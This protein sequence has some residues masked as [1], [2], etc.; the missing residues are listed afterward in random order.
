MLTGAVAACGLA[1]SGVQTTTQV[2][3][4]EDAKAQP[5]RSTLKVG[6]WTL[7]HDRELT[8]TPQT[9]AALQSCAR[10]AAKTLTNA[11][12][13]KAEENGL[14][15]IAGR[16]T[17]HISEIQLSGEILLSAHGENMTLRNPV[18]VS[19]HGGALVIA[20]TLPV[21]SYVARVVA[22]ESNATDSLET[23]K[24]LAIVVRS[25]ALHE[26]HGHAEYDLC[27]STHCQLLHWGDDG[28]A[29]DSAAEAATLSAAGETLW[30]RGAPALA[31]FSKDCGGHTASPSD[32]W[33]RATP[34]EYS[35]ARADH[36][37]MTAG[38]SDW[39]S[40][41]THAE[42]TRALAV[43]GVAAPGWLH[44]VVVR[45]SE[46]GRVI[47]LHID[48]KEV[49]AEDFRIAVG[50]TLGWNKI[51]ST[52]F[53][54]SRQGEVFQ[55]HGRGWGHGVGLCQKGAAAMGTQGRSAAG[56]LAQYFPGTQIADEATGRQWR[57]FAG[58]GVTLESLDEVDASFMPQ[59][60]QARAEAAQRSGLNSSAAFVVRAFPTT[61]AFRDAT[62]EPGWVAAF[63]RGD[64]I[65]TQ[66][67]RTLAA[68]HLLQTTLR[69]EFVHAL[70]EREASNKTPL[71]LREGLAEAWG[72]SAPIE[73]K[74]VMPSVKLEEL[75][76]ALQRA[77]NEAEAATAHRAAAWYAARL[78][79]RYGREQA[80]AWLHS[81]IPA[82]VVASFGQRQ[83]H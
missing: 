78:L 23:L 76:A 15:V 79:D 80:L 30:F 66:P 64:W 41:L 13:V 60:E 11:L 69:H 57:S 72:E 82:A 32:V 55:F 1:V 62:L 3:A 2:K 50:E 27:D 25:Y 58:R 5:A 10:C 40:Q 9:G 46:A 61:A 34:L 21:E 56:I 17:A 8:L 74:S 20:V 49:S 67:L 38:G 81:G 22:S 77:S 39:A 16:E 26:A 63:A 37:C 70:V 35:P 6:L 36:Y 28:R 31:Y 42:L 47:T 4:V 54:V 51:P 12:H 29:R 33:L 44:L 18:A 83:A 68:R 53:E 48:D 65:A 75:D 43:H 59:I 24:A 19:S 71:W 45:R 7:W 52:W 73:T 14:V